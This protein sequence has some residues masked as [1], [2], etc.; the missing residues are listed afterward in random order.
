MGEPGRESLTLAERAAVAQV[1]PILVAVDGA[2]VVTAGLLLWFGAPAVA[3]LAWLIPTGA[4]WGALIAR[5]DLVGLAE[6]RAGRYARRWMTGAVLALRHL[7][8][9]IVLVG[10]WFHHGVTVGAGLLV[11]IATWLSGLAGDE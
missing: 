4:V 2:A 1:H 11:V 8:T 7:G 9:A 6:T 5:A 3:L 10:A